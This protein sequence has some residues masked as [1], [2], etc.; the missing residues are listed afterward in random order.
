M[1]ILKALSGNL[2]AHIVL[3]VHTWTLPIHVTVHKLYE[4]RCYSMLLQ[5]LREFQGISLGHANKH[6]LCFT[7][8]KEIPGL[9]FTT[10]YEGNL[11]AHCAFQTHMSTST[12]K[13]NLNDQ[14]LPVA[15]NDF[16]IQRSITLTDNSTYFKTNLK[17]WRSEHRVIL[18]SSHRKRKMFN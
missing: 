11:S 16:V 18:C 10:T 2:H 7:V 13:S 3:D 12:T 6:Y 8:F 4:N 9:V 14:H 17:N 15:K 5:Y 1:R